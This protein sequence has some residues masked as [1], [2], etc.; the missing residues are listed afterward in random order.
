MSTFKTLLVLLFVSWKLDS[1]RS[2]TAQEQI[3]LQLSTSDTGASTLPDWIVR[4]AG[5][6]A[7][8]H[9]IGY[10]EA[11][12]KG[13]KVVQ[14]N[15]LQRHGSRYPTAKITKKIQS[16][17]EKL[18]EASHL[19]ESMNFITNYQYRL[20]EASL[21]P[22]GASESFKAGVQFASR[23]EEIFSQEKLPFVR[24]S[25]S[26]RVVDSAN[27]FTK[28][29]ASRIDNGIESIKPIVI[30]EDSQSNNTLDNNSCPNR[31]SSD[32]KDQ[33]LNIFGTPI[34]K[35]LNSLAPNADLDNEDTLA[36]MQ[37]CIFES[38]ADEKLSQFCDIFDHSDWPGYGYYYDLDKY[39]DRGLGNRLGQ[40]EGIGYVAELTTRMTGDR[41]WIEQDKS[42]VNQTLDQSSA[43]F[44][45]DRGIYIDF[46]HD[47]QMVA[48]LAALGLQPHVDLPATGPPPSHKI[49]DV[50]KW[51]PFAS[52]LTIE[53]L[54]CG[55]HDTAFVRFVLNDM[56]LTIPPCKT[57]DQ[58]DTFREIPSICLLSQFIESRRGLL[59]QSQ[60]LHEQ[61]SA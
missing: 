47:N 29:L 40:A 5:P 49:W 41:K 3:H 20:S 58:N 34:T 37:L 14:V 24:A 33:W 39:Y 13:C 61:C 4:H 27:N 30:S 17:L 21:L 19:D 9:Q 10:Y 12:S 35:R 59:S 60:D 38:L 44:P 56:I 36:L 28:G 6:I 8:F 51:M 26:E 48:I 50:S 32:E 7:P 2:A 22:L 52:R 25:L 1:K 43:T 31:P 55:H 57:S 46:S 18:T 45:L 16:A 11:P 23:Y 42:K 15:H 53:K 54:S